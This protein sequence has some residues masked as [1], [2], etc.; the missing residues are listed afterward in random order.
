M[1][2]KKPIDPKQL[3]EVIIDAIEDKKGEGI[4]VLD[5][6]QIPHA[7][8][9]YFVICNANSSTQ[10]AAIADSVEDKVQKTLKDKPWHME[11]QT[12]AEWILIDYV[13]VVVHVFQTEL[14]EHYDLESLWGDAE[15]RQI[16][17]KY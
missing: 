10:V 8:T 3:T 16:Q 13:N 15:I 5:L 9:D 2:I 1:S 11:G 14:R 4:T 6:T 12:N 7:V 17:S